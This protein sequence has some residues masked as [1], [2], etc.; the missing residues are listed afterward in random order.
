MPLVVLKPDCSM[1]NKS[2]IPSSAA[3]NFLIALAWEFDASTVSELPKIA[4]IRAARAH[5]QI[6]ERRRSETAFQ[7]HPKD[8]ASVSRKLLNLSTSYQA[9]DVSTSALL[10][11][12]LAV[13]GFVV[14]RRTKRECTR[15]DVSLLYGDLTLNGALRARLESYL[16]GHPICLC[17]LKGNQHP[18]VLQI[19]KT[20]VRHMLLR[21]PSVGYL[22]RN[23]VHVA[24]DDQLLPKHYL[25]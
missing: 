20:Y 14:C 7:G 4:R 25:R 5:R 16:L 10:V 23:L 21:R 2:R 3:R 6:V 9:T 11:R 17:L 24:D 8:R 19:W 12:S 18:C 22:L 15:S 1:G 13:L